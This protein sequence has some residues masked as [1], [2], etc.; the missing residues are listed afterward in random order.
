M[1]VFTFSVDGIPE[2]YYL[3]KF[4]LVVLEFEFRAS[5][6]PGKHSTT[7]IHSTSSFLCWVFLR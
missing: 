6:L 2:V 5:G 1:K 4:F 3:K 7:F